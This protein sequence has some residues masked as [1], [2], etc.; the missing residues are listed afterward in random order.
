M[1]LHKV[2]LLLATLFTIEVSARSR[3]RASATI[4]IEY[5]INYKISVPEDENG[6]V[7][8]RAKVMK[9]R[10]Q[11]PSPEI[12][13]AEADLIVKNMKSWS[14]NAFEASF[15]KDVTPETPP[16]KGKNTAGSSHAGGVAQ[17]IVR[18]TNAKVFDFDQ[19][20][21]DAQGYVKTEIEKEKMYNTQ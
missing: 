20:L 8:Y 13:E 12:T 11:T 21:K 14:E 17:R 7:K 9:Y 4:P 16:D 3:A 19:Q 5:V 18:V 15:L 10:T 2:L 1:L 6:I